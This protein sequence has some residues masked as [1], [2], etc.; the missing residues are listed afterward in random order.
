MDALCVPEED[1]VTSSSADAIAAA[2]AARKAHPKKLSGGYEETKWPGPIKGPQPFTGFYGSAAAPL[3]TFAPP[4]ESKFTIEKA[5]KKVWKG[6]TSVKRNKLR[7]AAT[8][9]NN[10]AA[11]RSGSDTSDEEGMPDL[12]DPDEMAKDTETL[13][14]CPCCDNYP[15][16]DASGTACEHCHW[17]PGAAPSQASQPAVYI[18][19][20]LA[21]AK[22]ARVEAI[23]STTAVTTDEVNSF[24]AIGQVV[25]Y[26]HAT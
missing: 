10:K 8:K 23:T 1:A 7:L 4:S 6:M 17:D 12:R 15:T 3:G 19:T 5:P 2:A 13:I 25:P 9:A 11:A 21:T 14:P 24:A 26:L 20:G 18:S 16:K 22:A